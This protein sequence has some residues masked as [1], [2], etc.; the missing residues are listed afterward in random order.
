MTGIQ[1][2]K[3]CTVHYNCN[4]FFALLRINFATPHLNRLEMFKVKG[5]LPYS[6]FKDCTYFVFLL[7]CNDYIDTYINDCN[8]LLYYAIFIITSGIPVPG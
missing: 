7:Y 2:G 1:T 8:Q 5:D 4:F 3:S 6:V